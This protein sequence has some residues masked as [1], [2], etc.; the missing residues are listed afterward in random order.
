MI[1]TDE[2]AWIPVVA[3]EELPED[4]A[5]KVEAFGTSVMLYR[6]G[7]TLFAVASRCTHQG[8]PLDRGVVKAAGS[9]PDGH[10]PG[11]RQRVLARGRRGPAGSG[12]PAGA[13]F[14]ARIVRREGRAPAAELS[15][16]YPCAKAAISERS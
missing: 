1:Q 7:E 8:A 15:R 12:H 13:V 14:E 2:N 6:S 3:T 10:L 5:T 4:R 9:D 16:G 11:A